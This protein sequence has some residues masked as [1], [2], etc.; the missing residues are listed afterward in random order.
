MRSIRSTLALWL[1]SALVIGTLVVLTVTYTL[2][3]Q[4]VGRLF[5]AE[6]EQVAH[7]VHLR[8]DWIQEGVRRVRIARPGFFLS[9]RAYDQEGRLF[10]ETLFPTLPAD[11]PR[12]FEE[13][14][15]TSETAE[16][17][18][19]V[20]THVVEAGVVQVGQPLATREAL[21]RGMAITVLMPMVVLIPLLVVLMA[22]LLTRGLAPLNET[23]RRVS[24]R[25]AA[26][27][28]PLPTEHVPQELLP[29]VHQINALLERLSGSLDAQRRFL[30]DAA[31]ELRSPVAALA[32]QVQLAA[33]AQQPEA[34][35]TAFRELARG[36]ER[37][38]RLV[39][40]LMDFARL[41]PGV[42][43]EPFAEVNL[44]A[45][46]REVVGIYAARA[47]A[48][49]VDLGAEAPAAVPVSGVES[50][51]RSLIENLVDNALRYAPPESAVTVSARLAGDEAVLSVVDA[52]RGIPAGERERVFERFHR[53]AGDLTPGTGLGLSIVKA[54][55]ERHAGSIALADALPDEPLPGLAVSIRLPALKAR[56][57]LRAAA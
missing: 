32:L 26:R 57:S 34:R 14:F 47:E 45:L 24:D 19:R 17:A 49:E 3:R 27:L 25:D 18:W 29:L 6:L 46:A 1:V 54:I 28:D 10:F 5:D 13:G 21:A 53:V 33:R 37:A 48:Q 30:A 38:R 52:G 23:S 22:W 20:Y 8:E 43:L 51:L 40:Q 44:A 35:A 16:G 15:T 55:V 39:Q 7:A 36:V 12:T 2:T 9:V 56:L 4:E 41:E 50:E 11:L 42:P 31:H